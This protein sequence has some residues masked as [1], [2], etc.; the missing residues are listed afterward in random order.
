M[1]S[2]RHQQSIA[3][4]PGM[5][6]GSEPNLSPA[7]RSAGWW[8]SGSC[9]CGRRCAQWACWTAPTGPPGSPMRR[10]R[11][12]SSAS[13]T[14]MLKANGSRRAVH[15]LWDH[16]ARTP[17]GLTAAVCVCRRRSAWHSWPP[18]S[19][20][21]LAPRSSSACS[22]T[23][24]SASSSSCSSCSRCNS[25]PQACLPSLANLACN[26]LHS[27][28]AKTSSTRFFHFKVNDD[29]DVFGMD[30]WR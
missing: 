26:D 6:A 29:W 19:S 24:P 7:R 17:H 5:R 20:A 28:H 1:S 14:L 16:T 22:C 15:L 8:R 21:R 9:A 10:A 23:T 27:V 30:R 25:L 4:Q 12:P 11:L 13:P 2:L 18:C 3:L